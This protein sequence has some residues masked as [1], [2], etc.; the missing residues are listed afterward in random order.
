MTN[1]AGTAAY[2]SRPGERDAWIVS[3]RVPRAAMNVELPYACFV[4]DEMGASGAVRRVA[5]VFL[6]NRE[7]PFHCL[8]CDLWQHTLEETVPAGAIAH[9]IDVALA[10][11]ASAPVIKLYNSGSFFD[12]RAIP[13]GD[14]AEIAARL[15]GF[16]RVIVECHPSFVGPDVERFRDLLDGELE[17]AMGLETAHPDVLARLNKRMT[18]ESYALAAGQLHAMGVASR[19][20]VLVQPPF[21]PADEASDW[22][23]RSAAFAFDQGAGAVSLI[24]VRA[25]NGALDALVAT[26]EFAPPRIATLESAL[27]GALA[28]GYGRAF[29]D[30]WDLGRFSQCPVCLDA[31]TERL[32]DMNLTQQW[33]PSV[34]CAACDAP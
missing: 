34:P 9:Q 11:L 32:R 3:R 17:V 12:H 7:C 19:A 4:E 22:A 20:F 6:T 25:G 24:P 15:S 1:A 8:M 28:L 30:T 2:P 14:F 10:S 26:G 29:A 5:T 27:D 16:R 33:L 23:V 21:M 18:L 13:P 31:R